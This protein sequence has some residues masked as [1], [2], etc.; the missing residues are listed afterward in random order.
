MDVNIKRKK[1][2]NKPAAAGLWYTAISFLEKGAAVIMTPIYTHLLTT[3]EYGIF[4]VYSGF[5]GILSVFL[6]LEISG[7]AVYKG[8]REFKNNDLFISS[9]IGLISAASTV[10]ILIYLPISGAIN[11]VTRL[12]TKISILLFIQAYLNGIRALFLSKSKYN[13]SHGL[14]LLEGIIF[15][16]IVPIAAVLLILVSDYPEYSRIYALL[17]GSVVFTLPLILSALRRWRRIYDRRVWSFLLKFTL[18]T[19]PHYL[20]LAIIW[21][22]G[23]IIVGIRF[24]ASEAALFS[25][26]VSIGFLP[27]LFSAGMQTALI[28]WITRKLDEEKEG[29]K[30]VYFLLGSVY[31]PI[32]YVIL[33]FLCFCPELFKILMPPAYLCA[34]GA[35]F[36]IAL[37]V[38][39]CFSVNMFSSIISYYKKTYLITL[40]SVSAAVFNVIL[41]LLF[42]FKLGFSFSALLIL[43][44]FILILFIYTLILRLKFAHSE[45]PIKRLFLTL[46]ILFFAAELIKLFIVSLLA[47]ALFAAALILLLIPELKRM[48]AL[49]L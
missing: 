23:K 44:S 30:K 29:I 37:S 16:A 39:V 36:P 2:F 9:A 40:G 4:S 48:R 31:S 47:R 49:M 27:S 21:Q 46:V 18:P 34:I 28:P 26:A 3:E 33:L 42:T 43:P 11:S 17:L 12:D 19:L 14:S 41:N 20:A 35:V 45:L 32:G 6:T 25:I 10:S 22:I 7:N 15:S 5:M 1:L 13:Y 8:L 24:S 38:F